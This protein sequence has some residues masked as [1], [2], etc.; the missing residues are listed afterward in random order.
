MIEDRNTKSCG[1]SASSRG[2]WIRRGNARGACTTATPPRR[3]E[4]RQ[5]LMLEVVSYPGFLLRAPLGTSHKADLLAIEFGNENF[6]EHPV[7]F[8]HQVMRDL[9]DALE[10]LLWRHVVRTGLYRARGHFLL[11]PRR[12]DLE[13]LVEA[14]NGDTQETQAFE[15]RRSRVPGLFQHEPVELKQAKFAVD[16]ELRLLEL[17][18]LL[19]LGDAHE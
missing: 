5:Q 7:L 16:V 3:A 18:G 12:A 14:G 2:S 17:I 8:R 19:Q 4:H 6:I 15:Q 9:G 10:H 13:E 11:E 1:P